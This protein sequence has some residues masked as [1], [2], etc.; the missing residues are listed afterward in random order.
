MDSMDGHETDRNALS[1]RHA[2]RRA[3][4]IHLRSATDRQALRIL[5]HAVAVWH[6]VH[7]AGDLYHIEPAPPNRSFPGSPSLRSIPIFSTSHPGSDARVGR[8]RCEGV[9]A[10]CRQA[11]QLAG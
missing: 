1:L 6:C 3:A 8:G 11:W 7:A 9:K 2:D 4:G 5:C 10:S